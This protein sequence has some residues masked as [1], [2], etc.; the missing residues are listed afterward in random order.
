MGMTAL[1]MADNADM[2][3]ATTCVVTIEE[4]CGD[5]VVVGA[6]AEAGVVDDEALA[7][8]N[9]GLSSGST[10]GGWYRNT[11]SEA[12]SSSRARSGSSPPVYTA[13]RSMPPPMTSIS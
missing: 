11:L 12:V 10:G 6:I 5:G 13:C 8:T 7:S 4:D 3:G 9:G 2:T 1:A